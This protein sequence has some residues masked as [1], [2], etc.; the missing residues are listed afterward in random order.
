MRQ[1]PDQPAALRG[2]KQAQIHGEQEA[3]HAGLR[4]RLV[5]VGDSLAKMWQEAELAPLGLEP[6]AKLAIAGDC[7]Q[8]VLW[9]VLNSKLD[10]A[11]AEVTILLAGT[12]NLTEGDDAASVMA[13]LMAID[14]ERKR[15]APRARRVIMHVPPRVPRHNYDPEQHRALNEMIDAEASARGYIAVP[16]EM[17]NPADDTIYKDGL[18]LY[19]K[20]YALLTAEAQK[21]LAAAG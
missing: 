6:F 7:T 10:G 3:L 8:H 14:D 16:L 9:R 15:R 18:H 1:R 2:P 4:P 11:D 19:R 17:M 5:L 21:A 20:A 12:N 13:G